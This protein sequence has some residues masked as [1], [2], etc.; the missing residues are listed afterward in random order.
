MDVCA[1]L[2]RAIGTLDHLV[3]AVVLCGNA[4][5]LGITGP[6][7]SIGMAPKVWCCSAGHVGLMLCF[8]QAG[9]GKLIQ[10]KTAD[11]EFDRLSP[12]MKK[13]WKP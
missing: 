2:C 5:W 3:V 9:G 13:W 12:R 4:P 10:K 11:F 8:S 6:L 1:F 7:F